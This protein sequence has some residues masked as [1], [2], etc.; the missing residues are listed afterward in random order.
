M[1]RTQK[2][3]L[4]LSAIVY[5]MI[6]LTA[7]G[8]D[9]YLPVNSQNYTGIELEALDIVKTLRAAVAEVDAYSADAKATS[10]S[11][12]CRQLRH[13]GEVNR[14]PRL[15]ELANA[16]PASFFNALPAMPESHGGYRYVLSRDKEDGV[17]AIPAHP[18]PSRRYI[19][20]ARLP[21]GIYECNAEVLSTGECKWGPEFRNDQTWRPVRVIK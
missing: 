8:C 1:R 4:G 5:A 18:G 9:R 19:F 21:A 2:S 16:L 20:Y 14:A 15:V 17:Y 12:L 13:L 10:V 3:G 11:Q 6:F 7:C